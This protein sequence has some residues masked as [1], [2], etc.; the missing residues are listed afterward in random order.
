MA[1]AVFVVKE[2]FSY[3]K[4]WLELLLPP[5]QVEEMHSA[6]WLGPIVTLMLLSYWTF[7]GPWLSVMLLS[8]PEEAKWYSKEG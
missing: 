1:C 6:I 3:R 4:N 7:P 8:L 2:E 5:R